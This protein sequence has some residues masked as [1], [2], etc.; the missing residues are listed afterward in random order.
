MNRANSICYNDTSCDCFYITDTYEGNTTYEYDD[1]FSAVTGYNSL[2]EI[3]GREIENLIHPENLKEFKKVKQSVSEKNP[4]EIIDL[5]LIKKDSSVLYVRCSLIYTKTEDGYERIIHA[6]SVLS[7]AEYLKQHDNL[8]RSAQPIMFK[9]HHG[10]EFPF[11]YN[12]SFLSAIGYTDDEISKKALRYTDLIHP[13]DTAHLIHTIKSAHKSNTVSAFTFRILDK[14]K[15]IHWINCSFKKM[16]VPSDEYIIAIGED[17]TAQKKA[18]SELNKNRL[19]MQSIAGTMSC[20]TFTLNKEENKAELIRFNAGFVRMFGYTEKEIEGF[21]E[22]ICGT[23]IHPEDTGSFIYA[24]MRTDPDEVKTC[25]ARRADGKTINIKFD[26]LSSFENG[27][28]CYVCTFSD[29]TYLKTL[30][31]EL[32][33]NQNILAC[34]ASFASRIS[35][36]VDF[37][38]DTLTN[39]NVFVNKYNLPETITDMP[40]KLI[41]TGMVYEEFKEE[42]FSLYYKVKN[43]SPEECVVLKIFLHGLRP[44]WVRVT[45][46]GIEDS[47][48]KIIKAIGIID[49]ISE[50]VIAED[51]ILGDS[52]N[53]KIFTDSFFACMI[54]LSQ[55]RVIASK[56]DCT[57]IIKIPEQMFYNSHFISSIASTV[58]PEDRISVTE[59]L[60]LKNLWTNYINGKKNTNFEYRMKNDETGFRWVKAYAGYTQDDITD[61][62]IFALCLTDISAEKINCRNEIPNPAKI[63]VPEKILSKLPFKTTVDEHLSKQQ[64]NGGMNALYL[65][66]LN[67]IEDIK[68][69]HIRSAVLK[70]TAEGLMRINRPAIIGKMYGDEFLIFI[71]D[72]ISYDDLNITAKQISGM[73][74]SMDIPDAESYVISGC[75]GVSFSPM[76]GTDFETLYQKATTALYNAKRFDKT[77][78][79]IYSQNDVNE[80]DITSAGSMVF[81]QKRQLDFDEFKKKASELIKTPGTR[82]NLYNGDIR[83][84]RNINHFFGYEKGDGILDEICMVFNDFL[85]PGEYFTRIFADNF[86]VLTTCENENERKSRIEDITAKLY[87][88]PLSDEH[89]LTFSAGFITIDDSNRYIEFDELIDCVI[90]AHEYDKKQDY[91]SEQSSA[92][93]FEPGMREKDLQSYEILNELKEA[94]DLGQICTFVQPQFDIL[95][96]EYVSMEALVRWNHPTK[97]ILTPDMFINICEE[98]GYIS[99][100]DFCVLEQMCAYIKK[101]IDQN[102]RILPVAIN[103]SQKTIHEEGYIERL[104]STVEKYSV[105]PRYIELEVTESAYVNKLD[106]TIAIL[107]QLREYGFRISMDDFGTGYSSLN[108][109][110]DIPVDALKIDRAF[111]SAGLVE[112][113]PAEI[114]KSITNMAHNINIKVVC[115]GVEYPQQ[116]SFLEKIGCELVQGY[117]FGKP[118]PYD[119]VADFIESADNI[120]Y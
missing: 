69:P 99:K 93:R 110:K 34:S 44:S 51:I 17:V 92:I 9:F 40:S 71:K 89:K 28:P 74:K 53:R 87:T 115:E 32:Q 55:C 43:G 13:K 2:S 86:L 114:I 80:K 106:E 76:H 104:I 66:D 119:E 108:F 45:L 90:V 68:E 64:F 98:H 49:D 56:N 5:R 113:K 65:L 107:T 47:S 16:S 30:E 4:L 105:P 24:L 88:L 42:L 11:F 62:I 27:K 39:H 100:I 35:F 63:D 83:H 85:R 58:Y 79:A 10:E 116:I 26:S 41:S 52:G 50:Q 75:V 78:Y 77:N 117:L 20:A 23:L 81:H 1:R 94:I 19:L 22:N 21:S 36:Y 3:S 109:L 60:S 96:H 95:K 29:I 112:K 102:L 57:D 38:T 97:G 54:N 91:P 18:E 120:S 101:R 7:D 73:C 67:G 12:E 14:Q 61:D 37:T 31:T 70:A 84:F 111:L 6:F 15:N 59:Q 118:M 33:V 25:R 103:Q 82:Y 8:A 46:H 72:I 48:G